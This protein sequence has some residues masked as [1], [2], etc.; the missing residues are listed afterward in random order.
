MIYSTSNMTDEE[1]ERQF[2]DGPAKVKVRAMQGC[3]VVWFCA[4]RLDSEILVPTRYGDESC[5]GWV[6][7]DNTGY[8]LIKGTKAVVS[9][10]DQS[11]EYFEL[12]GH[13]FCR[14]KRKALYLIEA[15]DLQRNLEAA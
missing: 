10:L 4:Y 11:G 6:M 2:W 9:R 14:V 5:E 13:R 7:D 1:A 12:E 3:A 15:F 8:G